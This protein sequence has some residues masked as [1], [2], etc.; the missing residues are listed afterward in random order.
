[1]ISDSGTLYE[2]FLKNLYEVC[3]KLSK[4]LAKDGEGATKLIEIEVKG[5]KDKYSAKKIASTIATSPLFKTAI[6]GN[7][8]NWG[9]I[10]VAAGRSGVIFRPELVDVWI[11]NILVAKKGVEADFSETKAKKILKNKEIKITVNL[12]SGK[13][14]ARYFTC[15]LSFGYIEINASYRS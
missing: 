8:A 7:D 13:E 5:A 15:D 14:S 12:N 1:M 2:V 4:M 3:F 11:G 10:M 9:R 6:F